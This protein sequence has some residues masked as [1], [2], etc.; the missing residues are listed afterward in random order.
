MARRTATGPNGEKLVL[1]GGKWVPLATSQG[2]VGPVDEMTGPLPS[3]GR[4]PEEQSQALRQGLRSAGGTFLANLASIPHAAGELLAA[5]AAV[6]Q[7]LAG[8]AGAAI[9]KQPINIGERFSS[10]RAQ[11]ESQLPA[12][13][14]LSMPDPTAEDVLAVPGALAGSFSRANANA[15]RARA[16]EPPQDP[17]IASTFAESLA[18]E[19][20]RSAENPIATGAGRVGGDVATLLAMRPG[21]RA[22]SALGLNTRA[23]AEGAVKLL[24]RGLARTAEAGIDGATIAALGDGDPAKTAAYSAG[25][26]AGGSAALAAKGAMLRNPVKTFGALWLGHQMMKA[27]APGPQQAFE[28]SDAA[29]KEL[30]AA[31][32]AGTVAALLGAGRGVGEG[33]VRAIT[34]ALSTASRGAVASGITQAQEEDPEP[35]SFAKW[36]MRTGGEF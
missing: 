33:N 10:A 26:Q 29:I 34:D 8:A 11:Q 24:G 14:L 17:T 23:P 18:R 13:A 9:R 1:E 27:V 3:L 35:R 4:N 15:K 20:Q 28:S 2:F 22:T 31:Y 25:I 32:G 6:P 36:L 19:Q 7:T 21:E 30:I 5:G 16:G 12:S